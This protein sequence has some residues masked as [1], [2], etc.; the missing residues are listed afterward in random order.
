MKA[1]TTLLPTAKWTVVGDSNKWIATLYENKDGVEA[2]EPNTDAIVVTFRNI[3]EA[4]RY[5]DDCSLIRVSKDIYNLSTENE[6]N[7]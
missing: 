4:E 6:F 2:C 1:E 3:E 7:K 5:Y